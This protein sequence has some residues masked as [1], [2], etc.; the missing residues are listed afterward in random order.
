MIYWC[1][2]LSVLKEATLI[3]NT[4]TRSAIAL[5]CVEVTKWWALSTLR[6]KSNLDKEYS[7]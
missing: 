2:P 5:H 1:L 3:G 7:Y 6:Q 4:V